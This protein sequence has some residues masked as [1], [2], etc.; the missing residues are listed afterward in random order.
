MHTLWIEQCVVQ[1]IGLRD[2]LV[3]NFNDNNELVI[4]TPMRLTSPPV[5]P[6]PEEQVLVD[7]KHFHDYEVPLLNFS[8][9]AVTEACCEENGALRVS[10]SHGHRIDVDPDE[11]ETA[12]ELY[13][14]R[15]G[16]MAC[17]PPGRVRVVRHDLPDDELDRAPD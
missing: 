17:L 1:R 8:G 9:A 11:N 4:A 5:E 7:P 12:W 14:R 16:Y 15:H 2:G 3:L 13:G 6:H 10:F